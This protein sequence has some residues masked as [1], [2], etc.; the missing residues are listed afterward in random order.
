MSRMDD[1]MRQA[2]AGAKSIG[3]EYGGD[4]EEPAAADG[5]VDQNDLIARLT[6]LR[7]RIS[8]RNGI[9]WISWRAW[10]SDVVKPHKELAAAKDTMNK[11]WMVAMESDVKSCVSALPGLLAGNPMLIC[12]AARHSAFIGVEQFANAVAGRLAHEL[13]LQHA[14]V[15]EVS[16]ATAKGHWP[17]REKEPVQIRREFITR[18]AGRHVFMIDDLATSGATIEHH[19]RALQE[20]GA[21]VT[22][23]AWIYGQV[24]I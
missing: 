21:F 6:V 2:N 19:A 10:R 15:F 16:K 12:P 20:E 3:I 22:S 1:L 5:Y 9:F 7:P 4:I 24:K 11:D 8:R 23:W 13:I 18:L 17:N 14:R